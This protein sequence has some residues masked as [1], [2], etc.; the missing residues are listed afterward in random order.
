MIDGFSDAD[1]KVI[2]GIYDAEED[3]EHAEQLAQAL[4]NADREIQERFHMSPAEFMAL[5]DETFSKLLAQDKDLQ[6]KLDKAK[7][8]LESE[9]TKPS[10]LSVEQQKQ[11][12]KLIEEGADS[13]KAI[14]WL[15]KHQGNYDEF[16]LA[17]VSKRLLSDDQIKE[18]I[19]SVV[20]KKML[21][22]YH[23]DLV[24]GGLFTRD[25]EEQIDTN[26]NSGLSINQSKQ[27][28]ARD[29][30]LQAEMQEKKDT[31][32]KASKLSNRATAMQWLNEPGVS[33]DIDKVVDQLHRKCEGKLS[34]DKIRQQIKDLFK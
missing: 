24:R 20:A 25:I 9:P 21:G 7:D 17:A 13:A 15:E 22:D 18:N 29:R 31:E 1:E 34:R 16:G 6:G 5:D 27:I 23:L 33:P 14:A 32:E 10:E 4:A 11:Y 3:R 12:R 2:Q 28:I 8:D 19:E 30:S 26:R